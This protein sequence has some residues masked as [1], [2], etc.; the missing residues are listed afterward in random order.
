MNNSILTLCQNET[1][2]EQS[3]MLG[4]PTENDSLNT[5]T[6]IKSQ[7]KNVKENP[8]I[9]IGR[10]YLITNLTND[11]KYVGITTK[12]IEH[13]FKQHIYS[14]GMGLFPI[15]RA[16]KKYGEKNFKIELLE[17]CFNI[18]QKSL[19]SRE[20]FYIRKYNTLIDNNRGYN[21]MEHD[22]R[23]LIFSNTTLKK[24]SDAHRGEK[25]HNYGK[26]LSL[27]YRKKISIS[28][29]G[30]KTG[31]ENHF[32]GKKHTEKTKKLIS[33]IHKGKIVSIESRNKMSIS[34]SKRFSD[35]NRCPNV[36]QTIRKF[37]NLQT[38]EDFV[39]TK[40]SFRRK[41]NLVKCS[42]GAL[43]KGRIQSLKGWVLVNA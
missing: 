15:A 28:K 31:K 6:N 37:K 29:K 39:G 43:V 11:K 40:C 36:E 17:E 8:T 30:K 25:N 33:S 16:I 22:G 18:P 5:T 32:F 1:T 21:L 27:E 42:V 4:V 3:K 9:K 35:I 14:R 2:Q 12:T 34:Q 19:L 24:K 7:N 38:N 10:V 23:R 26:I 41:Y 13:R 20:S